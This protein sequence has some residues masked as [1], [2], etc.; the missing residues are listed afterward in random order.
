MNP[1]R[2]IPVRYEGMTGYEITIA[3]EY[4]GISEALESLQIGRRRVFAVSE[5]NVSPLHLQGLIRALEPLCAGV[6][7]YV[8]PAGEEHKQMDVVMD[9]IRFLIGQ[10]AERGDV[11]A[12]LGGGV[13]GDLAGFAAAIYLRGIRVIQFPT[14]LLAMVD[15]SIGGKT[16]VDC[17]AFKNMIGAFHQ[18]SAVYMNL[19]F[20]QTL[21]EREY[22]SGFAEVIKH[23][24]L[25][26]R[27][28]YEWMRENR[29]RLLSRD[30]EALAEMIERSCLDKR[31]IV[32]QD[33]KEGGVR[34]LLNLGHTIGHA[35]EKAKNFGMLHGECVSA[36]CCA[37]A[38]LSA[39][40][41]MITKEE[42]RQVCDTFVSYG[43][44]KEVSGVDAPQILALSKSDKK[45]DGGRIRFI[46][47]E[48]IG[49][50]VIRQDVTEEEVLLAADS[51]VVE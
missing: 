48:A 13:C 20:L 6:S 8:F 1:V 28:L 44:P 47:L 18:P 30:E 7:S 25:C 15:S 34:A 11:I 42:Y 45:M 37:A 2:K 39:R 9:L 41:G 27:P 33:P 36:G 16:A 14:S 12:A 46:L 50:A 10:K 3:K 49:K 19:S 35:V 43:L 29:E 22:V 24:L 31:S 40:R 4:E 23:G 17:D 26:D 32:E 51:I 5:T 38:W 21:P